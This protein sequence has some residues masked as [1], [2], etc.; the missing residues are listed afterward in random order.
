M[1][2]N[3]GVQ[4]ASNRCGD[5]GDPHIMFTLFAGKMPT[6]RPTLYDDDIKHLLFSFTNIPIRSMKN[7]IAWKDNMS[8]VKGTK[9]YLDEEFNY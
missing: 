8:H 9:S 7:V 3:G 1:A 6:S 4:H 2:F 5:T